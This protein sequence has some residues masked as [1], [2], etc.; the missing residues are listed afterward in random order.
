MSVMCCTA[1][2]P[3]FAIVVSGGGLYLTRRASAR[4]MSFERFRKLLVQG[5]KVI[6]ARETWTDTVFHMSSPA[7]HDQFSNKSDIPP[8]LLHW[9][10]KIFVRS[11]S[12]TSSIT[13][14]C[15]TRRSYHPPFRPRDWLRSP[16]PQSLD[17]FC[18]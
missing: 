10:W 9:I 4:N 7:Y 15:A 3:H 12:H 2:F 8:S 1:G 17:L 18:S 6:T 14:F 5:S 16:V 13:T 11:D